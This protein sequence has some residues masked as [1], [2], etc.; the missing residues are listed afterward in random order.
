MDCR[1][2]KLINSTFAAY[3]FVEM[4][5]YFQN[6]TFEQVFLLHCV[7]GAMIQLQKDWDHLISKFFL[8]FQNFQTAPYTTLTCHELY[9]VEMFKKVGGN[10]I[11]IGSPGQLLLG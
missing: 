10:F 4:I 11:E 6:I 3:F 1:I 9:I 5:Q 2:N 7:G 8:I